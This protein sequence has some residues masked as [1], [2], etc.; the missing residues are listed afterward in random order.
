MKKLLCYNII[1]NP[2]RRIAESQVHCGSF[3]EE[4]EHSDPKYNLIK[5][6]LS[7]NYLRSIASFVGMEVQI[8]GRLLDNAGLDLN[9][10]YP[11]NI[12][13]DR[14]NPKSQIDVQMKC[15]SSPNFDSSREHLKIDLP[16]KVYNRL[17]IKCAIPNILMVLVLPK[18]VH[19]WI[20][21]D[22]ERLILRHSMY[23]YDISN[24]EIAPTDDQKYI[25]V[26]VPLCNRVTEES[27]YDMMQKAMLTT[28]RMTE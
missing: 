28:T 9:I 14:C 8:N 23:W 18:N 3:S 11:P 7:L 20:E 24:S 10:K 4:Y 16:T 26:K 17:H 12:E 13:T 27:L 15:T 2:V 5:E 6:Q 21:C 25:T 22:D 19:K 1:R